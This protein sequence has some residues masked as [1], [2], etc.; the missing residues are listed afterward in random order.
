MTQEVSECVDI[1][2]HKP[3]APATFSELIAKAQRIS[4]TIA[5]ICDLSA[6][7]VVVR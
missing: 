6:I 5:E 1:F 7:P 2:L 4:A 3:V